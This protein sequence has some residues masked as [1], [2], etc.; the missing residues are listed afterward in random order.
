MY[1][2][3]V[4]VDGNVAFSRI[5]TERELDEV[6]ET[7]DA[8]VVLVEDFE[9][10]YSLEGWKG[11]GV[12][13]LHFPIPDFSAPSLEELLSILRWIKAKVMEGKKVLIHCI[14]GCGRS[15]TVAVA[16]LIYSKR[17]PLRQALS[18][19]RRLRHCAV[20][21]EEQIELLRGLERAIRTR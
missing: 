13:V 18:E 21:T 5:P 12:E 6:A 7:F 10:P 1:P 2:S 3:A 14:G 4:F 15:G 17:L 8:V 9:L 19:V 11:R 16:W 20:E